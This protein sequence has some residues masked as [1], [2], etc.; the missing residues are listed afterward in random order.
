MRNEDSTK[1]PRKD[2]LERESVVPTGNNHAQAIPEAKAPSQSQT[3]AETIT[4]YEQR[5]RKEQDAI[6]NARACNRY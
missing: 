1:R 4:D 2:L 5:E 6:D 3:E